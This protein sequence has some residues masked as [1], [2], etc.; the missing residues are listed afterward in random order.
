MA[1]VQTVTC[2]WLVRMCAKAAC[3]GDGEGEVGDLSLRLCFK[4]HLLVL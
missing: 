4:L 2:E 1:S 3:L